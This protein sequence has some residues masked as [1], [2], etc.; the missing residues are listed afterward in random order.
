MK[1]KIRLEKQVSIL[2]CVEETKEVRSIP[3]ANIYQTDSFL[4]REIYYFK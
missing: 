4:E 3:Y 2:P 1:L